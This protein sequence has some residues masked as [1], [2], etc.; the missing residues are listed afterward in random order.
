MGLLKILEADKQRVSEL[1]NE[2]KAIQKIQRAK[3]REHGLVGSDEY[4][5]SELDDAVQSVSIHSNQSDE[6][7]ETNMNSNSDSFQ[8]HS[9][10]YPDGKKIDVKNKKN[11]KHFEENLAIFLSTKPYNDR[12]ELIKNYKNEYGVDL[13]AEIH[14]ILKKD[15]PVLYIINGLLMTRGQYDAMSIHTSIKDGDFESVADIL[16][17]CSLQELKELH[18]AYTNKYGLDVKDELTKMAKKDNK[19]TLVNVIERILDLQRSEAVEG[20]M[21]KLKEDL[22]FMTTTSSFK[23]DDKQRLVLI[24]NINSVEYVQKLN[25]EYLKQSKGALETFIDKKLGSKSSAGYFCKTRIQF[26][27]DAPLFYQ[28][29]VQKLGSKY[30]KNQNKI[31]DVFICRMEIDLHLIMAA[32]AKKKFGSTDLK[33]WV[34][35]SSSDSIS[36]RI[37]SLML[38]QCCNYSK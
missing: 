17:C 25:E 35:K 11:V 23:G 13:E 33:K 37:L 8:I 29:K 4:K 24:F 3:R 27:L 7:K 5:V 32:W 20:Q 9:L 1:Q 38:D 12:Q 31:A 14:S 10:L 21:D 30:K 16:C 22:E 36:G 15:N 6:E 2:I 28:K 19:K 18:A 26:A 34:I